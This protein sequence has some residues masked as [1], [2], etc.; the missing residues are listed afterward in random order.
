MTYT[1]GDHYFF[2]RWYE[3]ELNAEWQDRVKAMIQSGQVEIVEGGIVQPDEATTNYK[4][5]LRNFEAGHDW[6]MEIFGIKPKVA[7]QL[8][9]WGHS[10]AQA[11]IFA[12]LGMESVYFARMNKW[13]KAAMQ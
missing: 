1:I 2:R 6:L 12:E 4:D 3:T 8:D 10:S 9:P 13:F 5:V 7:W 11:Q